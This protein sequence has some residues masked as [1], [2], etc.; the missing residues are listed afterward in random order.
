MAGLIPL[1]RM[2][3]GLIVWAI[4]FCL[5]YALHGIGCA[6]GWSSAML[7]GGISLHRGTLI[8]AWLVCI[9]AGVG[10]ALSQRW[11]R[12]T[13]IARTAWRLAWVGVIATVATGLPIL[14][15]PACL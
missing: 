5:L 13:L 10:I 2:S 1:L 6:A 15:L 7:P 3:A 9:A 14:I 4:A 12:T 8:A 11:P